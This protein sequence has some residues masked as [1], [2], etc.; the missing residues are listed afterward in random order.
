MVTLPQ[1]VEPFLRT[2]QPS[3][4][5][6]PS[7]TTANFFGTV[8]KMTASGT[9]S[10]L[11]TFTGF[12]DGGNPEAAVVL[13]SENNLYGTTLSGGAN[14]E[15]TVFKLTP[16][17]TEKVLYNFTGKSDG[18]GPTGS[19]VRWEG[20]LYGTTL[21]GGTSGNGNVFKLNPSTGKLT[22]IYN[23]TGGAD[24]G[25]PLAGVVLDQEGNLYGTTYSGGAFG[26]GTLFKVTQSG[27]ETVF[28][29]FEPN[30]TDGF[31]PGAGGTLN[32]KGNLYGATPLGGAIGAGM[33]FE[34]TSSGTETVLHSLAGTDGIGPQ[35]NVVFDSKGNLYTTAYTGGALGLGSVFEVTPSGVSTVLHSFQNKG[36]DGNFPFAGVVLDDKGNLYGTTLNGGSATGAGCGA[37]Y[38]IYRKTEHLRNHETLQQ[39]LDW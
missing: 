7:L 21:T 22:N 9:F 30:G 27:K 2:R 26:Y 19:V 36:T 20:N 13:D 24:G 23:F 12:A 1:N 18:G 28:H 17:G 8:F 11:W 35:G 16:T 25:G 37:I 3:S 38:K 4:S 10:T 14:F 15:G 33:V 6:C 32:S 5:T 29:S 39:K 34:V 31:S